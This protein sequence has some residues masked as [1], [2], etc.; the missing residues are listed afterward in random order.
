MPQPD[1]G[2]S[3]GGGSSGGSSGDKK[4]VG[5]VA[6]LSR[7]LP[8]VLTGYKAQPVVADVYTLTREYIPTGGGDV[9][10]LVVVV[11]QYKDAAAAK[12]AIAII[13]SEYPVSPSSPVV[14]GRTLYFGTDGHRFGLVSWNE[15]GVVVAIEASSKSRKPTG[16][17]GAL[18]SIVG[19][20]VK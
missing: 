20:I 3:T 8:D 6:G 1:S 5:P 11:E 13:K 2:G 9:E 17:K 16:L 12:Q 15:N 19:G 14:K 7:F 10:S 18:V 4:P